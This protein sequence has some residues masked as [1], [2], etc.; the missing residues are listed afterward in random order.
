MTRSASF[1]NSTADINAIPMKLN[2]K[3]NGSYIF[4]DGGARS[5]YGGVALR[6]RK[7]DPGE[8]TIALAMVPGIN[9]CKSIY[10]KEKCDRWSFLEVDFLGLTELNNL[11][12][13][14]SKEDTYGLTKLFKMP[15]LK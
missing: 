3:Y 10:G 4:T 2:K 6:T 5:L 15:I 11:Y 7:I 8:Y 13:S 12:A 9:F 1:R 14:S